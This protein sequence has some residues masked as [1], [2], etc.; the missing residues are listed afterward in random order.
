MTKKYP[1]QNDS[2]GW[3]TIKKDI[4]PGKPLNFFLNSFAL[5]KS[6]YQVTAQ[7]F[8]GEDC[9]SKTASN[10]LLYYP[11]F[12]AAFWYHHLGKL[13]AEHS[14]CLVGVEIPNWGCS[15]TKGLG[16]NNVYDELV[17]L[18]KE[19]HDAI[20]E[21][22]V[23]ERKFDPEFEPEFYVMGNSTLGLVHTLLAKENLYRE[24]P[25]GVILD[26]AMIFPKNDLLFVSNTMMS[27]APLISPYK[28]FRDFA[29]LQRELPFTSDIVV[30]S[31][32][33]AMIE[34]FHAYMEKKDGGTL[35]QEETNWL[36][37]YPYIMGQHD[38]GFGIV[39]ERIVL[40]GKPVYLGF[41]MAVNDTLCRLH[42]NTNTSNTPV[43][44]I[45]SDETIKKDPH[46]NIKDSVSFIES[47]FKNAKILSAPTYEHEVLLSE[48]EIVEKVF[49][50]IV[51]WIT[52]ADPW[53]CRKK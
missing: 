14:I 40:A 52:T 3:R 51:E 36:F 47:T 26:H 6:D 13:F 45:Y 37:E 9:V 46:V 7:V 44:A 28:L 32:S 2:S 33:S 30:A 24:R 12:G 25:S 20:T 34:N 16:Y 29:T 38:D 42:S 31:D 18:V 43:L 4:T 21:Q 8:D 19:S 53:K 11:G 50:A 27:L 41:V 15:R 49:H 22:L 35:T 39:Q 10:F 1:W 48:K 17:M 5:G 23:A